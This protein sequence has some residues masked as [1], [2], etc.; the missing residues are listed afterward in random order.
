MDTYTEV[1]I[2]TQSKTF[3]YAQNILFLSFSFV[4]VILGF[5]LLRKAKRERGWGPEIVLAGFAFIWATGW[6]CGQGFGLNRQVNAYS[7]LTY[8]YNNH[9]CAVVEG[10]V[11][12]IHEQSVHGHEQ[13]DIIQV[14]DKE[15]EFNYFTDSV[16]FHQTISHNGVLRDGAYVRLTYCKNPYP[17]ESGDI[18]IRVELRDTK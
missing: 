16:G 3:N 2:F 13:G 11:Q 8:A 7:K 15:F 5:Y 10:K 4:A 14:G 6:G 1:F 17:Y 18:I 12:V 9:Q